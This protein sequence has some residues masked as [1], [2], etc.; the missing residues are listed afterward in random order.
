MQK[1]RLNILFR[2]FWVVLACHI[3]NLSI[4]APDTKSDSVPEDLTF[5]DI[6]SISELF[7]ENCLGM[8]NII[9]EHDEPDDQ[10]G[11]SM[12]LKKIDLFCQQAIFQAL[13][14]PSF[15]IAKKFP[16]QPT[17]FYLPEYL[18]VF[19]PPPKP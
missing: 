16:V 2:F 7:L 4:D 3:L 11:N 15:A 17:P 14:L 1:F 13:H 12:D 5:N 8:K 10:G 18:P 6:E 19:S 9:A